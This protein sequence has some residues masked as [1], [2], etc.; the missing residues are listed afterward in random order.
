MTTR[1]R[2]RIRPR[3]RRMVVWLCLLPALFAP[4]RGKAQEAAPKAAEAK[5]WFQDAKFGLFIHW[6]IYSV[7]GKGEW[8][9]ENDKIPIAE[10]QKLHAPVQSGQVRRR[11]LGPSSPRRPA[12]SYITITSKHHDGFC[13]FDCKLTDYDIVDASP[14]GK[15]PLKALADALPQA[16]HQAVLLLLAAR[17]ASSRLPPPGQDRA[18]R[19]T[20]GL[21]RLGEVRRLLPWARSGEL[22]TN[23]GEIGGIWFDGWWD[24]SG[25]PLG[26]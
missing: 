22:C 8:V 25:R 4:V 11:S 13:M 24:K 1:L 23:Y 2:E 16:G 18:V 9:M 21:G 20:R 17:L 7:L 10:Y 15:D 12:S 19:G 6:G 3:V 14:Y 5:V 26:P